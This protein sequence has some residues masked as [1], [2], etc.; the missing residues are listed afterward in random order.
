MIPEGTV[1]FIVIGDPVPWTSQNRNAARSAAFLRMQA[2]Q[3]QIAATARTQ[4]TA[5]G[6]DVLDQP[7]ELK[8]L[9]V[10]RKPKDKRNPDGPDTT[11]MLKAAED[12]LKGIIFTDD[13]KDYHVAAMKVP[14]DL[15]EGYT[16]I[17]ISPMEIMPSQAAYTLAMDIAKAQGIQPPA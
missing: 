5:K 6:Y 2:W 11:N 12:A 13:R 1:K 14:S 3:A 8:M 4:W 17:W 10:L 16:I 9:F 7:V 15:R